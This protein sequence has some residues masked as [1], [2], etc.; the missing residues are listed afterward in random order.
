MNSVRKD[1]VSNDTTSI[2]VPNKHSESFRDHKQHRD[3]ES[4][5]AILIVERLVRSSLSMSIAVEVVDTAAIA[6]VAVRHALRCVDQHQCE[7]NITS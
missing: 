7:Q 3:L 5:A 4:M 1:P 6:D 2:F